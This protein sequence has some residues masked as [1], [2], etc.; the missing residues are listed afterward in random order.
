MSR[1]HLTIVVSLLSVSAIG[2][3]PPTPSEF[4]GFEVGGDR[5]LADYRQITAYLRA[6]AA[7]SGKIQVENLG[8]TTLGN[9]LILAAISSEQ[10]LRELKKYQDIARRLADPRGLTPPEID[11]LVEQGK[12]IVLVTCNIHSTEIGASQMAMEWRTR[13]SPR[14]T[15][16][17]SAGSTM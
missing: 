3:P 16:R 8:P 14:K 10:N 5:Q 1:H 15:R 7:N 9:E 11:A 4:L 17:P 2:K 6:L 12:L 13:S